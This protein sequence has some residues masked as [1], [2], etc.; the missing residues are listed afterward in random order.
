MS[1][2]SLSNYRKSPRNDLKPIH[3]FKGP[4]P[5]TYDTLAKPLSKTKY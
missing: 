5:G 3:H 4:G 2:R 1:F